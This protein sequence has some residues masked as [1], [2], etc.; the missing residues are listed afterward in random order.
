MF[1]KEKAWEA[2]TK[3][4]ALSFEFLDPNQTLTDKVVDKSIKK[5]YDQLQKQ[6]GAQLRAG[7]L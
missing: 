4:C 6:V 3:S 5:I 7:E 1:I 2:G